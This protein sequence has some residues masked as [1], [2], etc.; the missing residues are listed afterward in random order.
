LHL[1]EQIQVQMQAQAQGIMPRRLKKALVWVLAEIGAK[2]RRRT[3]RQQHQAATPWRHFSDV[4]FVRGAMLI[5]VALFAVALVA[6]WQG[7]GEIH[8]PIQAGANFQGVQADRDD[9][10]KKPC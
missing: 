2:R 8:I 4:S 1:Q 3:T 9:C 10:T 5:W 6:D 7:L